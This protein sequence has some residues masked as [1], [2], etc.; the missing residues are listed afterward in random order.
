LDVVRAQD[1]G[2]GQFADFECELIRPAWLGLAKPA[3]L[4]PGDIRR[5]PERSAV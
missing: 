5:D 2:D 4:L 1:A 3:S